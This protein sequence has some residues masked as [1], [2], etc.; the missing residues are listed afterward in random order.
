MAGWSG[1][2]LSEFSKILF[3]GATGVPARPESGGS[4]GQ[5]D[6]IRPAL[7]GRDA[8]RSIDIDEAL[9]QL[10]PHRTFRRAVL[11]NDAAT[12]AEAVQF[13]APEKS[14]TAEAAQPGEETQEIADRIEP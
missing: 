7:D 2:V 14:A 10:G 13:T 12:F 4:K 9:L 5:V 11:R 3:D 1:S 8:R 6:K